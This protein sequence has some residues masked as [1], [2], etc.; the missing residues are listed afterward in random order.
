MTVNSRFRREQ[1]EVTEGSEKNRTVEH[2]KALNEG[3]MFS[4][5][6]FIASEKPALSLN[7]TS[8]Q[9]AT[10]KCCCWH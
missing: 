9:L 1:S 7:I 6:T 3:A 4:V 5:K 2:L 10:L 8:Q